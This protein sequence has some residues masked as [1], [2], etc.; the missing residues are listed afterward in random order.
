[1]IRGIL[2]DKDGTLLDFDATWRPV[3]ENTALELASQ[4]QALAA[5][6]LAAGGWIAREARYRPGSPLASGNSDEIASLWA[7]IMQIQVSA[8]LITRIDDLF[9]EGCRQSSRPFDGMPALIGRLKT[10]GLSLGIATSDSAGGILAT[11]GTSGVLADF[12]FLAGYDSGHGYKP[13]PG[14]VYG[15]CTATG[16]S[17]D[18]IAVVGDNEHD[19][20]MGRSA[21]VASVI[22]VLS[23]TG[24]PETLEPLADMV[25]GS[26]DE[27]ESVLYPH[28]QSGNGSATNRL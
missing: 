16:L 3:Y 25:I 18:E 8:A 1:M 17:P 15:F 23:G 6:M 24:T 12:V 9:L 13:G 2:F 5:K 14:M 7:G 21:G 26:V 20:E 28:D 19:M 10:R 27:L 11:L 4:D 22:G